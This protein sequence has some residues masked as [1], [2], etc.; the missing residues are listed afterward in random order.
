MSGASGD[1]S[2]APG[3][4]TSDLRSAG[5]MTR[6]PRMYRL[7]GL[8]VRPRGKDQRSGVASGKPASRSARLRT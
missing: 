5:S 7:H 6:E 1:R 3:A 2:A 8:Q 4:S